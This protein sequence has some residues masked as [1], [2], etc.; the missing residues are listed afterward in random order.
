VRLALTSLATVSTVRMY[1]LTTLREYLL[2]YPTAGRLRKYK[3]RAHLTDGPVSLPVSERAKDQVC[4][5]D[6]QKTCS[7]VQLCASNARED[8]ASS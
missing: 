6:E 2:Q 3:K 7:R 5:I 1:T 4:V 8:A